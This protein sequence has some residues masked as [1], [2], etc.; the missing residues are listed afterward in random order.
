MRP[1]ALVEF[2][3]KPFI[4]FYLVL[5]LKYLS[6]KKFA[7]LNDET[8]PMMV[9]RLSSAYKQNTMNSLHDHEIIEQLQR[10]SLIADLRNELFF[11]Q[12]AA[13]INDLVINDF[14]FLVS[15]LYRIDVDENKMRALIDSNT[16]IVSGELIA[17]L[18]IERQEQK[19]RSKKQFKPPTNIPDEEKW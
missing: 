17:Q 18:I 2:S 7:G 1:I 12:L 8:K 15:L 4:N 14:D 11:K 3:V 5:S 13:Y 9:E 10:T 6:C 16:N 19:I